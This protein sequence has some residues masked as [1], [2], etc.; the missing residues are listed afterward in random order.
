MALAGRAAGTP[1]KTWGHR[2]QRQAAQQPHWENWTEMGAWERLR[3]GQAQPTTQRI[4]LDR[5]LL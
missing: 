3:G 1:R 4:S 2:E 5:L